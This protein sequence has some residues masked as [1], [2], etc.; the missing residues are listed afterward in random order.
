MTRSCVTW[1]IHLWHDVLV[2]D[3]THS[4]VCHGPGTS[5]CIPA[6]ICIANFSSAGLECVVFI[7]RICSTSGTWPYVWMS[8]GTYGRFTSHIWMSHSVATIYVTNFSS[9]GQIGVECVLFMYRICSIE[10]KSEYTKMSHGTYERVMPHMWTC[11]DAVTICVANFSS[12]RSMVLVSVNVQMYVCH[13][14]NTSMYVRTHTAESCHI[15]GR[16]MAHTQ[17][18]RL[19]YEWVTTKLPSTS[20]NSHKQ[21]TYQWVTARTQESYHT[22][23]WVMSHIHRIHATHKNESQH[24]AN[25]PRPPPPPAP[26]PPAPPP[27]PALRRGRV[28]QPCFFLLGTPALAR[29]RPVYITPHTNQDICQHIQAHTNNYTYKCVCCVYIFVFMWV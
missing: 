18:S 7:C 21:V 28:A 5:V 9:A 27:P 11:H 3:V 15:Y 19:T 2:C 1:R 25:P 6:T 14:M 23:T 17:E 20:P 13:V 26:P 4:H 10:V 22:R 8:P 12:A 16:V 24:I 29:S